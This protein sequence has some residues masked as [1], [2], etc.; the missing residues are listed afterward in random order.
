[1]DISTHRD[2]R[3][4]VMAPSPRRKVPLVAYN[5][6]KDSPA[7]K[8][9]E[10]PAKQRFETSPLSV[11]LKPISPLSENSPDW[12][13]ERTREGDASAIGSPEEPTTPRGDALGVFAKEVDHAARWDVRAFPADAPASANSVEVRRRRGKTRS[14]DFDRENTFDREFDFDDGR[15]V[16]D[17]DGDGHPMFRVFGRDIGKPPRASSERE[18]GDGLGKTSGRG[19]TRGLFGSFRNRSGAFE[20]VGSGSSSMGSKRSDEIGQLSRMNSLAETKVLTSTLLVRQTSVSGDAQFDFDDHFRFEQQIGASQNSEVWLVTSKVSG[21]AFV[22][23]KCLHSF[24]TEAQRAKYK[25]E[26]EAAALLPEHPNIV[27]YY[28]SWQQDQHFYIQM[29]H[30]ACGSL[31]SVFARLPPQTLVAELDVWRL[32]EQTA[33]GLAFMHLHRIIHLDVKPDNIYIDVSG[34][35]KIG[36]F[37]LAYVMESGWD[38]EE[39]DGGYLAPELLNLF[40]GQYPSPSADVFSLGVTLYEVASGLKFPRG[41]TPRMAIPPLPEGRSAE[42][43]RLIAGCLD[44]DPAKRATAQEV[45]NFARENVAALEMGATSM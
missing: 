34:T 35:C 23:K 40:P 24:T 12:S 18:E 21:N 27:R 38:W 44:F 16:G 42:L 11:L 19:R 43:A 14:G 17:H 22:V 7:L 31:T 5:D 1:M 41:A 30:C 37:G 9:S 2:A 25:R 36:D 33:S 28:R 13:D 4:R 32:A 10:T 29:E 26:V 8:M 15:G 20:R 3:A 45:A 39:G 6:V